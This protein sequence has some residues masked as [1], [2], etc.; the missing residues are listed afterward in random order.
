MALTAVITA[1]GLGRDAVVAWMAGLFVFLGYIIHL[2]LDE[3]YSVDF[4]GARIK[5]SFGSALKLFERRSPGSSFLMAGAL[6]AILLFAPPSAEFRKIM[7]PSQVT[8]F[9][10]ERMFPQNGWFQSRILGTASVRQGG[11]IASTGSAASELSDNDL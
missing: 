11:Y 1:Y 5:K 3:I 10:K 6:V 7:E 9:F 8:E 4:T 2:T